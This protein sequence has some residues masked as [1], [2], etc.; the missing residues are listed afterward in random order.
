[1]KSKRVSGKARHLSNDIE[2]RRANNVNQN[3]KESVKLLYVK[4]GIVA[5]KQSVVCV[6][7]LRLLV[8]SKSKS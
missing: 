8:N 5:S 7:P 6:W 1:M 3:F 2:L 4:G